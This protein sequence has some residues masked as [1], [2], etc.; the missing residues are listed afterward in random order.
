VVNWGPGLSTLGSL[1]CGGT[2][3]HSPRRE[4][5]SLKPRRL[6]EA[7][8]FR[9]V[10]TVN[11]TDGQ[12]PERGSVLAG[13][14]VDWRLHLPDQMHAG[15]AKQQRVAAEDFPAGVS[16]AVVMTVWDIPQGLGSLG[17]KLRFGVLS[18]LV[19]ARVSQNSQRR[20]FVCK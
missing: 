7:T 12:A 15:S 16:G 3:S 4:T 10:K 9:S 14:G 17:Y 2:S 18:I 13:R 8:C 1:E 11:T 5:E 6:F 19:V 20:V